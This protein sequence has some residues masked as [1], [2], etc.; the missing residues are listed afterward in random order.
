[1]YIRVNVKL[2]Y[3]VLA[4]NTGSSTSSVC[5]SSLHCGSN[6]I[7]SSHPY[8]PTLGF[9]S[10]IVTSCIT[11][12]ILLF[13]ILYIC[14]YHFSIDLTTFSNT[15]CSLFSGTFV[16]Y[17]IFLCNIN[18]ASYKFHFTCHYSAIILCLYWP[19][20]YCIC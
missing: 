16:S 4:S 14:P 6:P 11:L 9:L 5:T 13:S 15:G 19:C 2:H 12:G 3:I 17:S 18:S 1:M 8:P 7:F 10:S 20:F